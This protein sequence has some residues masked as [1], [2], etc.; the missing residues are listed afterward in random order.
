MNKKFYLLICLFF[1]VLVSYLQAQNPQ[2]YQKQM[3]NGGSTNGIIKGLVLDSQTAQP[4]EYANIVL[5]RT[6]DSTMING[7]V[8][9]DKGVFSLDNLAFGNY[10]ITI[11]FMGY[12]KLKIPQ[13]FVKPNAVEVELGKIQLEPSSTNLDEVTVTAEKRTIE[14][15]LDKK[16][17]NVDKN[18]ASAGGTA[19]DILQNVPSVTVDTEGA[20]SLRGNSNVT[21]LIDG[22]PSNISGTNLEQLPASSIEA[23]EVITNPSAKYNPEGMSGIINIRLKKRKASG[24][25]GVAMF[26][27][28]YL[29]KY[30][31]SLNLNY[32][33]G[34]VNLFGSYDFRAVNMTNTGEMHRISSIATNPMKL[35]ENMDG[36]RNRFNNNFKLGADIQLNPKNTI[37]ISWL[38]NMGTDADSEQSKSKET[39]TLIPLNDQYYFTI[40]DENEN[41]KSMDFILNYRKTFDQ[42]ERELTLDAVHSISDE[43][44]TSNRN[45]TYYDLMMMQKSNTDMQVT[46]EKMKRGTTNIQLNYVHPFAQ[47]FRIETGLQSIIRS[48]NDDYQIS[49]FDYSLT[50]YVDDANLSNVFDYREQINAVYLIGAATLEKNSIQIGIRMEQSN[51]KGEQKTANTSFTKNYLNFFPSLHFTR[52]LT[53]TQDIQL[54]YSRRINRPRLEMINP[55]VDRSNPAMI[56]SGNPQINPEFIDAY[57]LGYTKIMQ[58]STINFTVFY[59]KTTDVINRIVSVDAN[60]VASVTFDNMSKATSAGIE[61]VLDQQIF[62]WWRVNLNGSYF[63]NKVTGSKQNDGLTNENY[64][65]NMRMVSNWFL[66]KG[67]SAQMNMSYMGP[68]VMVQSEMKGIFS[69]D[70][71]MKKDVFKDKASI[72]IR[73]SDVF[74]TQKFDMRS[75]GD[76]FEGQNIRKRDSRAYFIG[77]TYK[78]G[79]GAKAKQKK[80]NSDDNNN[81]ENMDMGF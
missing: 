59:R 53:N 66:G 26:N 40:S 74:N 25:N 52:K 57:E 46:D 73:V 13:V 43:N 38:N 32:N 39:Y 17:V 14:Y 49:N 29:D 47:K 33:M 48:R 41:N 23:I 9:N 44:G 37:T 68:M 11:S 12:N 28:G 80:R 34:M 4:V 62:K 54:G 15:A 2:Q 19:V 21:I 16:I 24:F 58:K 65:W 18:I 61:M 22:R 45:L 75:Y 31:G 63:K 70:I 71:A 56:R 55:F 27:A 3:A 60:N 50:K 77:F 6:K 1:S 5:Y 20:V 72:N 69:T 30:N 7:T 64:S 67:L 79:G 42:K 10:Y 35:D 36:R 78:I 8:T 81:M 76:T 51:S